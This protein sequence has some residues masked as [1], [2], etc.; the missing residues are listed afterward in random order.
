MTIMA[1]VPPDAIAQ[2]QQTR[3]LAHLRALEGERHPTASPDRLANAQA[4]VADQLTNLGIPV[5][6]DRFSFEGQPFANV[7]G[8][9][10]GTRGPRLIVGA[11]FDTV[12]NT[13]GADDNASGVAVMLECARVV[14]AAAP[15]AAVEFVGFN[16]E[17]F[18]MVGSRHYAAA[19]RE[20][21]EPL[22]GML[23]LEM[24]GFTETEGLQTYP[25]LLKPFFP[26]RGDFL[27]LVGNFRS[28]ALLRRVETAM[29]RI[30]SL[31][32][33]TILLPGRG[34]LVPETR[35]SDHSPF[36]DAG[37]PAL[38]VTDTAFLRNPHYHRPT[39]TLSTLNLAFIEKVCQAVVAG[40]L[41][42]AAVPAVY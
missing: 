39:D 19:L 13:S 41:D 15:T 38:L 12:P 30:P 24:L 9:L 20:H 34:G 14:M 1:D 17:E 35:L 36:W 29:R 11:H 16:L 7:I 5:M 23:S 28:R 22:L 40:I 31:P 37:Y 26:A 32:I 21:D 3:L 2:V 33:Q 4:Y 18:G 42:I 10:T 8:R 27:G 25:P 6:F